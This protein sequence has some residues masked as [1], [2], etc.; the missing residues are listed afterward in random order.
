MAT[1]TPPHP[2]RP[3]TDAGRNQGR[4]FSPALRRLYFAR[5]GRRGQ[6]PMEH[7]QLDRRRVNTG[8]GEQP[9]NTSSLVAQWDFNETSGTT[10]TA[11]SSGS[12][13]T[14]CNGTLTNFASTGSQDA[15]AGTGWTANNKN[16][17][18]RRVKAGARGAL[19]FD[20]TN[21][22]VSVPDSD[23]WNFGSGDLSIDFWVKTNNTSGLGIMGQTNSLGNGNSSFIIRTRESASLVTLVR[24]S[25]DG[26]NWALALGTTVAI[27]DGKWHYVSITRNGTTVILYI[28]GVNVASGTLSG[29][30]YNSTTI[31][32]IGR[33]GEITTLYYNGILDSMR[34]YKGRALSASEI[35]SNYQA[36]NIEIQTRSGATSDPNDGTWEAWKPTTGET[37][38]LS[39]DS[40]QSNW[41]APQQIDGYTKLLLPYGR[42]RRRHDFPQQRHDHTHRYRR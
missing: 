40:D 32:G 10:L 35:L 20:G 3:G 15:A 41:N 17:L 12:C 6:R 33:P 5:G 24:F 37:Q 21:D 9:Y 7:R 11:S 42:N 19:M 22:Y 13:T 27:D 28:D 39:M 4:G 2:Q 31:L 23:N 25:T 38:L 16:G 1:L 14:S 34:I 26:T 36:G 18:P 29:A 8:N 30:I